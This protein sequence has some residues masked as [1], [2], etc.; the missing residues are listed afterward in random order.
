MQRGEEQEGEGVDKLGRGGEMGLWWSVN[1][2]E[3]VGWES[4]GVECERVIDR[5]GWKIRAA[6]G[7][8]RKGNK[9]KFV[10]L[11]RFTEREGCEGC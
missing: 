10:P 2:G 5:K 3:E 7:T 1:E 11:V 4:E 8:G 9:A 6:D